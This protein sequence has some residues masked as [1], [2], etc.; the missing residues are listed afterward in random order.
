MVIR[1]KYTAYSRTSDGSNVQIVNNQQVNW[2]LWEELQ[3]FFCYNYVIYKWSSPNCNDIYVGHTDN[4][5]KRK[6]EHIKS[7]SN[8]KTKNHYCKIYQFI[9]ASGGIDNW[10]MEILEEFYAGSRKEAEQVEQKWIDKLKPTL[11]MCRASK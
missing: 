10:N 6:Q 5:E 1:E 2:K 9:R 7:C 4:F 8:S 3:K 11:N